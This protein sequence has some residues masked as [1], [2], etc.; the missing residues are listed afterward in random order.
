MAAGFG[1]VLHSFPCFHLRIVTDALF[2][3]LPFLEERLHLQVIEHGLAEWI[4]AAQQHEVRV[5]RAGD[6]SV[7]DDPFAA[8]AQVIFEFHYQ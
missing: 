4:Y 5:G 6:H 3:P 1:H 2:G 8:F 7:Q